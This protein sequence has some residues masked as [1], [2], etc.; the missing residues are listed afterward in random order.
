MECLVSLYTQLMRNIPLLS[1]IVEN[2]KQYNPVDSF[3]IL[4]GVGKFK[5]GYNNHT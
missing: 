5:I 3:K 2:F 4:C 1:G